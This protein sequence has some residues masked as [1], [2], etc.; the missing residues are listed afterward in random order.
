MDYV[1]NTL[2]ILCQGTNYRISSNKPKKE[3][4]SCQRPMLIKNPFPGKPKMGSLENPQ[5]GKLS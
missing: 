4:K 3:E 1:T 2:S 5:R